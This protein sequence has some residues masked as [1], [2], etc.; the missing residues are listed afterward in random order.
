M[1][2]MKQIL[3]LVL[4]LSMSC[5]QERRNTIQLDEPPVEQS[6]A[7]NEKLDAIQFRS[8]IETAGNA[9]LIDIRTPD[10][11]SDG[12]IK[13]AKN[14]NFYDADFIDQIQVN[15]DKSEPVYLYCRSGGRS[16]KAAS[17]LSEMGFK[18]YD[19]DGGIIDWD[20]NQF[21]IIRQ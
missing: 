7:F 3:A 10:E 2:A 21:E 13:D 20:S 15:I 8:K 5:E 14:I 6:V 1:K 4:I 11:F 16:G 19:L 9:Q 17:K 12:H 18:V